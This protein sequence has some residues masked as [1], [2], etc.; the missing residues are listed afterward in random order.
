[1]QRYQCR[2]VTLVMPRAARYYGLQG[3]V[4]MVVTTALFVTVTH[5]YLCARQATGSAAERQ[6]QL[7]FSGRKMASVATPFDNAVASWGGCWLGIHP[8][9][10]TAVNDVR[11]CRAIRGQSCRAICRT[12]LDDTIPVDGRPS[13]ATR[14]GAPAITRCCRAMR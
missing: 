7:F 11:Y 4:F 9:Q 1:M 5:L 14:P 13:V 10:R 2:W 6:R 3:E 8:G 12:N